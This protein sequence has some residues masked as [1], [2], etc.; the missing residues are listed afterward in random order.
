MVY[1][2]NFYAPV[3][4]GGLWRKREGKDWAGAV[5]ARAASAHSP[6]TLLKPK[7]WDLSAAPQP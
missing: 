4:V 1:A 2:L 5:S 3:Q 7:L 6:A